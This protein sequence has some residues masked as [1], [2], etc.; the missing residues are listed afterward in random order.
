MK[1]PHSELGTRFTDGLRSDH[2]DSLT[3]ISQMT[4]G[5]ITSITLAAD[6]EPC[7]TGNWRSY[8]D[9]IDTISFQAVDHTLTDQLALFGNHVTGFLMDHISGQNSPEHAITQWSND[10]TTFDD[11][12]HDQTFFSSTIL[13]RNDQILGNVYQTSGQITRVRRL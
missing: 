4:T 3:D 5:Q 8:K 7:F 6:T 12:R 2:A 1:S 11:R 13:F 10:V 9:L